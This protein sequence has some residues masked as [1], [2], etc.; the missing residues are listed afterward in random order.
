MKR[1]D[2]PFV[3][4]RK[5]AKGTTVV[6]LRPTQKQKPEP[7]MRGPWTVRAVVRR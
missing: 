2:Q 4:G 6:I 7:R 3:V 1:N 5:T